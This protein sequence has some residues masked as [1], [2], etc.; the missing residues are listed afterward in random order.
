M[1][2]HYRVKCSKC[3][4]II[5]LPGSGPCPK[6]GALLSVD[7]P[8]SISLYRMGNFVG[9]A[10][11]FGIYVNEVPFG[12]IGNRESLVLPLPYGSYKLHVVCGMNR[13]CNDPVVTLSPE[14]PRVCMKVHMKMGFVQNTFL[15]ERVDP[16]TMPQ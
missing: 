11:G 7:A 2:K 6:C 10:N 4:E 5:N 14:D 3:G 16:S 9:S 13:K 15:L 12:A 8:A 1:A